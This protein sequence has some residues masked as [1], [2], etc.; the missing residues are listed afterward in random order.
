[1]VLPQQKF[2]GLTSTETH[3]NIIINQDFSPP[4]FVP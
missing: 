4:D 2:S 1:M 3:T